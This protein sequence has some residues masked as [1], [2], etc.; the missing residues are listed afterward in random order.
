[1]EIMLVWNERKVCDDDDMGKDFTED[2]IYQS[3]KSR[4]IWLGKIGGEKE[5]LIFPL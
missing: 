4:N 2:E 3:E 5:Y 1:M